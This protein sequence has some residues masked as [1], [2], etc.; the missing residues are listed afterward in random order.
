MH[1]LQ[2]DD[3]SQGD[4]D[5]DELTI[6]AVNSST[7]VTARERVGEEA[8]MASTQVQ[9]AER[10]AAAARSRYVCRS[11]MAPAAAPRQ[12]RRAELG[13]G[14]SAAPAAM[15]IS[16]T[17]TSWFVMCGSRLVERDAATFSIVSSERNAAHL[18]GRDEQ[19]ASG[20]GE[21]VASQSFRGGWKRSWRCVA[22]YNPSCG[23]RW[24]CHVGF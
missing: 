19:M 17:T 14:G 7:S 4:E 1:I 18:D 22:T 9:L 5:E 8:R 21:C 15:L 6:Q 13:P 20:L 23:A 24:A 2:A 10:A 11:D 3:A 12:A 16:E